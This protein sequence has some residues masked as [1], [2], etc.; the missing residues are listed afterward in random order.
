MATS[1]PLLADSLASLVEEHGQ[2]QWFTGVRL[3]PSEPLALAA[4]PEKQ[5][6]ELLEAVKQSSR[7]DG[8]QAVIIAGGPLSETAQRI[9]A[10][11]TAEIIQPVPSACSL[12]LNAINRQPLATHGG[13]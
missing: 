9:A 10:T 7:D 6:Q 4:E 2:T 11:G 13:E 8:A 5:F 12:V 1:T 3:T